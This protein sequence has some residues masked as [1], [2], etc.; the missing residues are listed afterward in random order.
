MCSTWRAFTKS[1][2]WCLLQ[3][4][5]FLPGYKTSS[6]YILFIF[7]YLAI[8]LIPGT[9]WVLNKYPLSEWMNKWNLG[10]F[11]S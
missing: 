11:Y 2:R 3:S 9:F 4:Q 5:S 8:I 1:L 10:L 6:D 7:V